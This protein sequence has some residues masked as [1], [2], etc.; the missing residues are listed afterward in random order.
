MDAGGS[1]LVVQWL[2]L[3]SFTVEGLRWI[4]GWGTTDPTSCVAQPVNRYINFK[5]MDARETCSSVGMKT[6]D[7]GSSTNFEAP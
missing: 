5:K 1:P 6:R 2:G 7:E 3:S 4:P